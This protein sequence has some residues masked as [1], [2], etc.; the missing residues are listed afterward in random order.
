MMRNF[1]HSDA[2]DINEAVQL[3]DGENVKI[4]AGGTDLLGI[5]KFGIVPVYPKTIVNIKTIPGMSYIKE[6][7][8]ILKIGALTTLKQLSKNTEIQQRYNAL[9]QAASNVASPNIRTMGTIA[10]NICQE[11][12]CWY[13]RAEGNKFN[14]LKKS[15]SS[16]CYALSGDNRYHS[17]FGATNGCV[18]VNPS[19][20]APALVAFGATVITNKRNIPINDFFTVKVGFGQSGMTILENDEIITEIQVPSLLSNTKSAFVKFAMRKSIDFPIVNCAAVIGEGK[21]S[22]CLN[23]VG[24]KPR[25][26]TAAE[27]VIA[28]EEIN[29]ESAE[30]AAN[31]AIKGAIALPKNKYIIQIA[32]T[33]IKRAI[34]ACK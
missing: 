2:K 13:F 12:R 28:G 22:I 20:I 3:L 19:D 33:M 25:K 27:E 1:N 26:V 30:A 15:G 8:D 18:C 5:M 32:K 29:E 14:C 31:A 21:A 24:G 4:I 34:I 17:I 11:T 6:E 10:G 9:Q 7:G 16:L 23:A